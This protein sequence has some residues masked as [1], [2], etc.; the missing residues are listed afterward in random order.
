MRLTDMCAFAPPQAPFPFR[1]RAR[2]TR[3]KKERECVWCRVSYSIG[4]RW[5]ATRRL[6]TAGAM[7]V[8][9]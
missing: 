3:R 9:V 2:E 8:L 1:E 6:R 7:R 5:I 4:S